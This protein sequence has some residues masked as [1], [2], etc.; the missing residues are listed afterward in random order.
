MAVR[1]VLLLL[2]GH[3][4]NRQ[5]VDFGA[6][7]GETTDSNGTTGWR[8]A[9]D[10]RGNGLLNPLNLPEYIYMAYVVGTSRQI[11]LAGS[12][13]STKQDATFSLLSCPALRARSG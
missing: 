8:L 1:A 3:G 4:E 6:V 9:S 11:I 13:R 12:C 10:L 2:Y 7:E 5:V